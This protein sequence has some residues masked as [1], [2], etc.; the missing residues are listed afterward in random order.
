M[1]P[2]QGEVSY[3]EW[4]IALGSVASA[5]VVAKV[6]GFSAGWEHACVYTV[7]LFM[8]L[9]IGLRPAWGLA[10]L[11]RRLIVIFILH[12]TIVFLAMRALPARSPG[13]HG[14]PAAMA[15]LVEGLVV[16]CILRPAISLAFPKHPKSRQ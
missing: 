1:R 7:I 9:I 11:W 15:V 14:F 3:W 6:F 13:I 2:D 10:T 16:L 12:S 8:S 5:V 4:I